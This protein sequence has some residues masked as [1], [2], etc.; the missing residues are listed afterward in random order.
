VAPFFSSFSEGRRLGGPG[1]A[2]K[3]KEECV[4]LAGEC[5]NYVCRRVRHAAVVFSG[6]RMHS[7]V[8]CLKRTSTRRW[9]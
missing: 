8:E 9:I 6:G 4:G 3:M 2:K 1:G 5:P 7:K